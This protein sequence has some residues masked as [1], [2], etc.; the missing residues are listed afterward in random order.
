MVNEAK[1]YTV[2]ILGTSYTLRSDE[3]EQH[4]F[5]AGALVDSLVNEIVA[6]A[7]KLEDKQIAV[8]AALKLASKLLHL[9]SIMLQTKEVEQF[10]IE[11]IS[12]ELADH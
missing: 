1:K 11:Q 8:L 7:D 3:S 5:H 4:V 2:T 10:L 6:K 12:E 9:E